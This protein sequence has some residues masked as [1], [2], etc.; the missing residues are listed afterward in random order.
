MIA[1]SVLSETLW[2]DNPSVVW[3]L[4]AVN[5]GVSLSRTACT[6]LIPVI[7]FA[8]SPSIESPLIASFPAAS[9]TL[10]RVKP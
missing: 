6:L 2:I 1:V 3:L 10:I 5:S 9:F 4:F 8:I 7:P